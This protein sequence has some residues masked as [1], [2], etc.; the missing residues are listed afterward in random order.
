MTWQDFVDA[1]G[2]PGGVRQIPVVP[3][4]K[5]DHRRTAQ[6]RQLVGGPAIEDM[7]RGGAPAGRNDP[8][9]RLPQCRDVEVIGAYRGEVERADV[10]I[11]YVKVDGAEWVRIESSIAQRTVYSPTAGKKYTVMSQNGTPC[12][13]GEYIGVAEGYLTV[14]GKTTKNYQN[15]FGPRSTVTC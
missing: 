10:F 7:L 6:C 13:P 14:D 3:A 8:H 2:V 11:Y 9:R 1:R 15:G 4:G 12:V 5:F